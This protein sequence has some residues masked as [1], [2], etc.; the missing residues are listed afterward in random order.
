MCDQR[1]SKRTTFSYLEEIAN[2]FFNQNSTK[3][4]TVIRPFS[5]IEFGKIIFFQE[6]INFFLYQRFS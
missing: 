5:L 6:L 1:F 4:N 2:L 3:I